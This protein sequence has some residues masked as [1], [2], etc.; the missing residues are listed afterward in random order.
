MKR[1]VINACGLKSKGGITIF[2]NLIEDNKNVEF[3]I[4]YDNFEL[5][6]IVGNNENIFIKTPRYLH[7]ILNYFIKKK[8]LIYINNFDEIIHLGNFGFKTKLKTYTF[9]QNVLPIV[10][11]F[12][13]FRNFILRILYFYSFKISDEIIVQQPHVA[14]LMPASLKIKIIGNI[15]YKNI[16][17]SKNKGFVLIYEEI[18]NKNPRF[19]TQLISEL[20]KFDLQINIVN[21]SLKLNLSFL[22]SSNSKKIVIHNDVETKDLINIFKNNSYYIHTSNY[23]TVGLPI[24]EA[25]ESGIKVIVPNEE[26][27]NINNAN[28]FKYLP[29]DI[30]S[31]MDACRKAINSSYIDE[32]SVPIYY[33]DWNLI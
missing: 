16:P 31:L 15:K 12:G 3:Y 9:V 32:I 8:D 30:Q 6:Q 18:K 7:I 33:E 25:L 23:E 2:K 29:R 13:S 19:V 22:N 20:A 24:Y 28:I 1:I 4:I 10:S 5:K 14:R 11:P 17:Q 21:S 27:I 26:Y